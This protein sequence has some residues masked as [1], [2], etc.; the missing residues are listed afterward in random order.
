MKKKI[1][2]AELHA[3]QLKEGD[4][5]KKPKYIVCQHY[6]TV[7]KTIYKKNKDSFS[8]PSYINKGDF[9]VYVMFKEIPNVEFIYSPFQKVDMLLKDHG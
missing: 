3:K 2:L 4:V 1:R 8:L 5:I 7:E 6:L 9:C